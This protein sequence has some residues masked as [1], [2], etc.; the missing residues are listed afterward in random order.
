MTYRPILMYALREETNQN[1][2]GKRALLVRWI[3]APCALTQSAAWPIFFAH[4]PREIRIIQMLIAR[5]L[6]HIRN[7]SRRC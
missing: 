6:R 4:A 5:R 7:T 2:L 1:V 3:R